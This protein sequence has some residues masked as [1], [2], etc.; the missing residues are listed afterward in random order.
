MSTTTELARETTQEITRL[1]SIC[2]Y[3]VTSR[4]AVIQ[5]AL[6]QQAARYEAALK[7]AKDALEIIQTRGAAVEARSDAKNAL[8]RITELLK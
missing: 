7:A 2:G 3:S 6:D 5:S 4:L 1:H 8:A